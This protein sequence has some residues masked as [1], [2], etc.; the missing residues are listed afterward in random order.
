MGAAWSPLM[1]FQFAYGT[2]IALSLCGAAVTDRAPRGAPI[3]TTGNDYGF[4]LTMW[5]SMVETLLKPLQCC[6][7]THR[8]SPNGDILVD[9][10]VPKGGLKPPEARPG[11]A[12]RHET[13]TKG[14]PHGPADRLR[15]Y[16][17]DWFH[18]QCLYRAHTAQRQIVNGSM[19]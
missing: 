5:T 9:F 7:E 3:V 13:I 19:I 10:G 6:Q 18:T 16:L 2:R 11:V 12:G 4:P 8:L 14:P 15:S 17:S 1:D